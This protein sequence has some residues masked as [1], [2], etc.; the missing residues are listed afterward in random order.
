MFLEA[1]WFRNGEEVYHVYPV[2]N[3]VCYENM[4]NISEIE[5]HDGYNWHSTEN[6]D[7]EV[8][9]FVIRIKK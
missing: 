7:G 1:V 9:N 8:D 4:K 3:I 5:V 6:I 2:E